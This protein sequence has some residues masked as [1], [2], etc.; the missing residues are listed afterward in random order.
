MQPQRLPLF[1]QQSCCGRHFARGHSLDHIEAVSGLA[2]DYAFGG[3]PLTATS[4]ERED[5]DGGYCQRVEALDA[6]RT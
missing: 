5:G 3:Q 1:S 2:A 6:R 4:M